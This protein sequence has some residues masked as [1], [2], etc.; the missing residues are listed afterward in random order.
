MAINHAMR[1]E[2]IHLQ[3]LGS[4]IGSTQTHTLF[5]TNAMQAIRLVLPAGKQIA[6]HKAPGEI[7]VHCLEGRIRFTVGETSHELTAG[8]MLYL[9]AAEPHAVEAVIDSSVLVTMLGINVG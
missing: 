1:A 6:E 7:T 5:K 4:K 2:V 9:A 3:P 8:D